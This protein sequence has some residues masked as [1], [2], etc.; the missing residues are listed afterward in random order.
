[1]KFNQQNLVVVSWERRSFKRLWNRSSS[2]ENEV[3]LNIN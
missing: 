3:A 1:M 2:L